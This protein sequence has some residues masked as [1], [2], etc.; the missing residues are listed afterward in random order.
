MS[1]VTPTNATV[2]VHRPQRITR[3]K[4]P[5]DSKANKAE[6]SHTKVATSSRQQLIR[7]FRN[8]G[9][10][11]R[12][13]GI[14]N[15]TTLDSRLE[16]RRLQELRR[17]Q[18]NLEQIFKLALDFAPD[19]ASHDPLDLDWLNT[20]SQH[21][22]EISNPAMQQLWSRILASESSRPGSF[23]IRTLTTLR[24]LTSRE[25]EVLRRA[26]NLTAYDTSH[27][28]YK[29]LTG[30]YKRP[31][32][33]TWVTLEKPVQLNIAKTGLSY[34]DLLTLS[35]LGVLYPS[36]IESSELNKGQAFEVQFGSQKVTMQTQRNA[37]V[38]TYYKYTSQ[39]EEL[40]RLLPGGDHKGY[41][42]LLEEH[43]SKDFQF[44]IK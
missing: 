33:F 13:L 6:S 5:S 37:I 40:L 28:S 30:Y 43:C 12:Q 23:S 44:N 41:I 2:A 32:L 1:K 26:Q 21:A 22:Q 18:V 16:Q 11:Y 29:I 25:A 39:G 9:I 19:R 7:G 36:A 27:G 15:E 10:D 8:L 34:P 38:L 42:E 4:K 35:D 3:V 17:R 24:Q 20:F 14:K 31:S